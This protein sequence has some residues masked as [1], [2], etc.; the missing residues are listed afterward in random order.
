MSH[1]LEKRP[2]AK[3]LITTGDDLL[4]FVAGK[5]GQLNLPGGGYNPADESAEDALFREV[6]EELGITPDLLD[7]VKKAF[8]IPIEGVTTS[9][10]GIQRLASWTVFEAS[11]IIPAGELAIQTD[12]EI[13]AMATVSTRECQDH[14]NMSNLAR[15]TVLTVSN[16]ALVG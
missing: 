7:D 16:Y 12:S 15:F 10:E 9:A 1:T 2:A 6:R 5:R 8:P 14:P 13:T 4:I 11:L 3:G